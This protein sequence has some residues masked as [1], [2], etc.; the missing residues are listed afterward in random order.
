MYTLLYEPA[1]PGGCKGRAWLKGRVARYPRTLK[2]GST[3]FPRPKE[4]ARSLLLLILA[5]CWTVALPSVSGGAA[6]PPPPT[7]TPTGSLAPP[8][9]SDAN[10]ANSICA[11][12]LQMQVA[13]QHLISSEVPTVESAVHGLLSRGTKLDNDL[14]DAQTGL[15][16]AQAVSRAA[17]S[18][19]GSGSES[20]SAH[21]SGATAKGAAITAATRAAAALSSLPTHRASPSDIL[22]SLAL[23]GKIDRNAIMVDAAKIAS[24]RVAAGNKDVTGAARAQV[25]EEKKEGGDEGEKREGGG[26]HRVYSVVSGL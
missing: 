11:E 4:M 10:P 2:P 9:L 26:E 3:V 16:S 7:T 5:S 1:F 13:S 21:A 24:S 22:K 12:V 19:S 18:G 17:G 6:S 8:A 15:A 23:L 25:R 20:G 14:L